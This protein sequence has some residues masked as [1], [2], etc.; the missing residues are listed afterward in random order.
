MISRFAPI[1][2]ERAAGR[3]AH[4]RPPNHGRSCSQDL[5]RSRASVQPTRTCCGPAAPNCM[6]RHRTMCFGT[7]CAPARRWMRLDG[8]LPKS[9]RMDATR[10]QFTGE[11]ADGCDSNGSL[12]ES[13]RMDAT[14]TAV[15]Q[16]ARGWIGT[17]P[18]VGH[19]PAS[20]TTRGP[21][22]ASR[23]HAG[24]APGVTNCQ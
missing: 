24:A 7:E 5:R 13:T 8:S 10:W 6:L 20:E 21:R 23:A 14:Q 15:Y 4:P 19:D 18:G 2:R 17:A 12:P 1:A 16:R 22:D 11:H 3:I 9:T